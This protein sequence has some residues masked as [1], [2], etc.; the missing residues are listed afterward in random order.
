MLSIGVNRGES[1]AVTVGVAVAVAVG[2]LVSVLLFAHV[3]IFY[4]LLNPRFFCHLGHNGSVLTGLN[5]II[6]IFIN[7]I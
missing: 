4:S 5:I 3:T 7:C 1:M 2:L 6:N